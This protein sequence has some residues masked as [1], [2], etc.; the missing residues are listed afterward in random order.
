MTQ[1]MRQAILAGEMQHFA[2]ETLA[3]IAESQTV[4]EEL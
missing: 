4:E 1:R 3:E 2:H